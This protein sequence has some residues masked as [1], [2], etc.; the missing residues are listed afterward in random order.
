MALIEIN[1]GRG[2]TL[3]AAIRKKYS[4]DPGSRLELTDKDGEIV[5]TPLAGQEDDVF[6]FIDKNT[7]PVS[8][9][10]ISAIKKKVRMHALLH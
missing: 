1:K 6:E 4:L 3:P 8:D 9:A 2:L 5:L 7:K 10:D